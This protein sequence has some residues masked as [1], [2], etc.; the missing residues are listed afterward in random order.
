MEGPS[1]TPGGLQRLQ[2]MLQGQSLQDTEKSPEPS[3]CSTLDQPPH[4]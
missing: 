1:K 3:L 4:D 2:E